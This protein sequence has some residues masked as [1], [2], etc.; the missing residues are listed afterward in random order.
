MQK[1]CLFGEEVTQK[2]ALLGL[3]PL[4]GRYDSTGEK[5]N[6]YFS[7]YALIRYRVYIEI[8]WLNFLISNIDIPVLDE[9]EFTKN[10]TAKILN[11]FYKF[12]LDDAMAVK[13]IEERTKHD[14]K[15]V[16]Y[17]IGQ[18]LK[19]YEL[20]YLVPFVH[21]GCTSED[22]NNTAYALM[23]SESL[24]NVW[25][26]ST[27]ELIKYLRKLAE[28]FKN[29]PMLGH[30]HGQHAT[31]VTVGKE[32]A[33]YISR[34]ENVSDSLSKIQIKGKFNGATGCYSAIS[35]A[36]PNEN[37]PELC[38]KF[39]T[40]YLG[41]D[42]NPI[43]TQI[44]PHDYVVEILDALRHFN[45]ILMDLN[46]DMW[47]YIS[48]DYIK[49]IPVKGEVGSSVMPHKVNP[50]WFEN[51]EANAEISNALLQSLSNK[52]PRSRMQRDLSDSS[53]QRNI[54]M[55]IGYSLLAISNTLRGL[56]R[57]DV[58]VEVIS[59]DLEQSWEVLAEP[60]QTML[61]KYGIPDAYDRL[62]DLT[63]G[64]SIT[65]EIIHEFILSLDVLSD[66]DRETLLNLSP[67]KYIGYA[68][69]IASN[70]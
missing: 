7:E 57:C 51:S 43:T 17:F 63:R 40:D 13:K 64:K 34:L 6:E 15:A 28:K 14:V 60:I 56:K 4:D 30:T 24:A 61:R 53:A 52:L 35:T 2:M 45:N 62:K 20:E 8:S 16:E 47:L 31:P 41:L 26:P 12:S 70:V 9:I 37:W 23:L 11:I 67:D 55:A 66:E 50:I 10:E 5:L 59:K 54:G 21:I 38:K 22:I 46:V 29:V 49:Q 36:F 25:I 1:K 48:K 42:F 44:E 65:K 58:N 3:S 68:S 18:K 33:V 32:F 69:D 27:N 39:V 19:E